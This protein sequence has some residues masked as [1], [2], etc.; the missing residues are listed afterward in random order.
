MIMR[1]LMAN[2]LLFPLVALLLVSEPL[3]A[4]PTA[5]AKLSQEEILIGDQLQYTLTV[6]FGEGAQID[7]IDL[8]ALEKQS[9]IEILDRKRSENLRNGGMSTLEMVLTLTSFEADAYKLPA[10]AVGYRLEGKEGVVWSNE[11]ELLVKTYP[12]QTDSLRLMPIKDIAGEPL[13][14]WDILPY[15]G[16]LLLAIGI[17][18]LVVYWLRRGKPKAAPEKPPRHLPLAAYLKEQL[19]DLERQQLWQKGETKAYHAALTRL[20]REY[21]EYRYGIRAL[22]MTTGEIRSELEGQA[23]SREMGAQLHELLQTVDLVKFA[24]A[25]PPAHFHQQAME[26]VRQ[27]VQQTESA[28][29]MLAIYESGRREVYSLPAEESKSSQK[30]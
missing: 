15:I 19:D 4:Q 24:K 10:A 21:L 9:G 29:L 1:K 12:V 17:V 14:F 22:E 30:T 2:F 18:A 26:R 8:S 6:A 3:W 20:L 11:P 28:S 27:F 16:G 5:R 7:T 23:I 25:E 13:N